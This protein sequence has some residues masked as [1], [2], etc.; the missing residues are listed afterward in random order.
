MTE[1]QHKRLAS[2]ESLALSGIKCLEASGKKWEPTECFLKILKEC[3]S[4][5]TDWNESGP[6][7]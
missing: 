6:E 3:Q 5:R 1:A 2:I 7:A 4:L